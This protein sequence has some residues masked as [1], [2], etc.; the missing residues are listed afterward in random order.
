MG[1]LSHDNHDNLTK[2]TVVHKFHPNLGIWTGAGC[3]AQT[4]ART[5]EGTGARCSPLAPPCAVNSW[6]LTINGSYFWWYLVVYTCHIWKSIVVATMPTRSW[7]SLAA[8]GSLPSGQDVAVMCSQL[9]EEATLHACL[10]LQA[11]HPTGDIVSTLAEALFVCKHQP[12]R[13]AG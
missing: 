12:V 4:N 13:L 1:S 10:Q 8:P 2:S 7:K 9:V 3:R 11:Y 6:D 5:E